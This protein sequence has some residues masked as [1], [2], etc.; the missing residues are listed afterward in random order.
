[1]AINACRN[2]N[3]FEFSG[4]KLH[5]ALSDSPRWILN[6][7]QARSTSENTPN[8]LPGALRN[9]APSYSFLNRNNV[10][11]L[12]TALERAIE[13][14]SNDIREFFLAKLQ[15]TNAIAYDILRNEP[16]PCGPLDSARRISKPALP[17]PPL[18]SSEIQGAA[19]QASE[20]RPY[21][22]DNEQ[23]QTLISIILIRPEQIALLQPRERE[24]VLAL[25]NILRQL[26]NW[27]SNSLFIHQKDSGR[28]YFTSLN[29]R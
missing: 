5:V 9:G 3:G 10:L 16:P 13:R 11:D 8:Q 24:Y 1:M 2:L 15:L 21:Q 22:I 20:Q 27:K 23:A 26:L 18:S 6:A 7:D 12:L 14:N 29:L 25:R 28:W 4:R 17:L 19:S